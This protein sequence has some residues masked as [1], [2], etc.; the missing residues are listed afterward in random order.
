MYK[1]RKHPHIVGVRAFWED[2]HNYYIVQDIMEGGELFNAIVSHGS[3]SEAQAQKTILTLLFTLDYCHERG[4]VHRDLK[5]ENILLAEKDNSE[6][7][8]LADFG[9]A[10]QFEIA[11]QLRSYCGTPGYMAPEIISKNLY[12]PAVDMWSLGVIAYIL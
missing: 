1:L 5:P 10:H 6:S 7:I 2:A 9:L 12:G 11:C 3:F 8:P 4:I